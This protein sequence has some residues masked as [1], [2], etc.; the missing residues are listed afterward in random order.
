MDRK[1]LCRRLE[2]RVALVT[3]GARGIGAATSARLAREGAFVVVADIIDDEGEGVAKAIR[4]ADERAVFEHLD[5]SSEAD[6]ARVVEH[7]RSAFGSLDVLV[8]NA[9]VARLED[10]EAESLDGY[11]RLVAINQTGVWLGMKAAVPELRPPP[12]H[13]WRAMTRPM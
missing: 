9:G 6:W 4:D 1:P 3:G 7:A 12:L 10:V 2:R 11:S 8:N 13:F 5:V